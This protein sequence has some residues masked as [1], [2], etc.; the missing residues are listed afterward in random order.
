MDRIIVDGKTPV[1]R[2]LNMK[3][4]TSRRELND[5]SI[6]SPPDLVTVVVVV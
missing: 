1:E 2:R 6:R 4:L 5:G 3:G